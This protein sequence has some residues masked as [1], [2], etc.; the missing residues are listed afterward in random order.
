MGNTTNFLMLSDVVYK[1]VEEV[2]DKNISKNINI[3]ISK[4]TE[5][6][7]HLFDR[8]ICGILKQTFI[9][10]MCGSCTAAMISLEKNHEMIKEIRYLMLNEYERNRNSSNECSSNE[11]SSNECSSNEMSYNN[12]SDDSYNK[13]I[14]YDTSEEEMENIEKR[15]YKKQQ[16]SDI[17][18][19]KEAI[20]IIQI[21]IRDANNYI[22][23]E[24]VK[25][26]DAYGRITAKNVYSPVNVPPY[27]TSVKHGYAMLAS[28][29]KGVRKVLKAQTTFDKIS[30]V[31]GTCVRVRSGD[32]IPNGA[33]TVVTPEN[34]KILDECKDNDDDYF[35]IDKEYEIEVLVAPEINENIRNAGDEI[36]CSQLIVRTFVCLGPAELGILTLCSIDL[37]SVTELPS[38][39]LLSI[40][41][42]LEE[43]ENSLERIHKS[44]RITL[45]SLLKKNGYDP[46]DFGISAYKLNTIIKKIEDALNEV[47]VLV[48]MGHSNDKDILKPIL[49]E[50]FNAIIHF[51]LLNM[52][53]GKSTTFASCTYNY[54]RKFFLCMSANPATVPI[55]AH[56]VLLPL[57]NTMHCNFF[58]EPIILQ[59]CMNNHELHLRPKFSW[60]TIQWAEKEKF[61]RAYCSKNQDIMKYQKANAL[62]ML[63]PR[64]WQVSK[65]DAAFVSGM[66]FVQQVIH[67]YDPYNYDPSSDDQMKES[68]ETN[69][70]KEMDEAT[71]IAEYI[72]HNL[73]GNVNVIHIV[74]CDQKKIKAELTLLSTQYSGNVI[75]FVG[76]TLSDIVHD[77]IEEVIDKIIPIDVHMLIPGLAEGLKCFINRPICGIVNGNLVIN[78]CGPY[79][80][81]QES[82]ET[83]GNTILDIVSL[84]NDPSNQTFEV[85][86]EGDNYE[87]CNN[88]G[89]DNYAGPSNSNNDHTY[90]S[91]G[92]SKSNNDDIYNSAG[93]SKSNINNI[94]GNN[95]S[96]DDDDNFYDLSYDDNNDNS[97]GSPKNSSNDEH[98][99]D[100]KID[101]SCEEQSVQLKIMETLLLKDLYKKHKK[102][103]LVSLEK[104]RDIMIKVVNKYYTHCTVIVPTNNAYGRIMAKDIHSYVNVPSCMTSSKHGYAVLASDGQGVRKVLKADLSLT[105]KISIVPGTC[106]RVRSGDAIPDGATAVVKSVD[107]QIISEH[108]N[109][110]CFNIDHMEY[111]IKILV[112]PKKGENIREAGCEIRTN[113]II[114]R[115]NTRVKTADLGVLT[116]CGIDS[117]K[118]FKVPSVGLLCIGYD[119]LKPENASTIERIYDCNKIIVS[120]LLK[121]NGYNLIDFGI[122]VYTPNIIEY[123]LK[124]ALNEVD[125]LVIMG[126]AND[127]DILK[128]ILK[129]VFNANI[130][131]GGVNIKPGKSTTFATC[132]F[133][134]KRKF[135][136]CMSTNPTTVP[137]VTH[138]LLLP[139]LNIL[140]CN[141]DN[142]IM[143]IQTG[144]KTSHNLHPR[145]KLSWTSIEWS[146]KSM[147][148]H[149]NAYCLNSEH[150]QMTKYQYSNALLLLPSHTPEVPKLN[151]NSAFLTA[152]FT[153]N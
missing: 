68:N 62:L 10:N 126:R 148:I 107:T 89:N 87:L 96:F 101:L 38:V 25:M 146:E 75:L 58:K 76:N 150:E 33:N 41:S 73:A 37:I 6:L 14:S 65:L 94:N 93:P 115:K 82:L 98:N 106:M 99:S 91:A 12:D 71:L 53:P 135:F 80:N 142:G 18:S 70:K 149:A 112:A 114:K 95:Y 1:A 124:E 44:N 145:P 67:N 72:A 28:D 63:P 117:I 113:D 21:I 54:K 77:A 74:R 61:P 27:K 92:P 64:T 143:Q 141:K 147:D 90:N 56:I 111:Q 60:T 17:I 47:D 43:P 36:K 109:D 88:N 69:V 4:L 42:E 138:V 127:K 134:Q 102:S 119:V 39:G 120:S 35:N 121:K 26:N 103:E 78:M 140:C 57:L 23:E 139:L 15:I 24:V 130:H 9:I 16:R 49:R 104:A 100:K 29:G 153:G 52:K 2:I 3:W 128:R 55:V 48:I 20:H 31:P 5:E 131:F 45:T 51:G 122:S 116:L 34:I 86:K 19:V 46:V 152:I 97:A 84:M 118:V 40:R 144:I 123:R 11:S 81:V 136:L 59:T 30:V 13:L 7:T 22:K 66:F 105:K 50:Y 137:I 151:A 132:T 83:F 8:F 79:L 133:E 108:D 85:K 129:I 110:D 32:P 125:L